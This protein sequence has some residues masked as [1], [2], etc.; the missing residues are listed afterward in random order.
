MASRST[1]SNRATRGQRRATRIPAAHCRPMNRPRRSN[2]A[3]RM[4]AAMAALEVEPLL[5]AAGELAS[6]R[7]DGS[8]ISP[9]AVPRRS[10]TSPVP[11]KRLTQPV[12]PYRTVTDVASGSELMEALRDAEARADRYAQAMRWWTARF[13]GTVARAPQ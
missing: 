13:G 2:P 5:A 9:L 7:A 11:S 6:A 8:Q 1:G 10:D 3:R 12:A 4:P